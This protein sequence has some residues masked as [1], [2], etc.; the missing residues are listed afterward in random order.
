MSCCKH[1]FEIC[2]PIPSCLDQLVIRTPIIS[3]TVVIKFI[4]KFDK[5]YYVGKD[6]NA[7][8]EVTILL[9]SDDSDPD[10]IISSDIPE[11]LLNEYAGKFKIMTFDL[12]G[13]IIKQWT[14]SGL[15]YD[16]LIIHMAN[17][18]PID[19][20]FTINPYTMEGIQGSF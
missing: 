20:T 11:R 12:N 17:I 19:S 13:I 7:N 16:A 4:D 10:N 3:D 18:T 6:T 2:E 14:I 9:T 1:S 8:G 15:Q 5:I